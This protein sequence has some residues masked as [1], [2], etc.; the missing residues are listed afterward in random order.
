[1]ARPDLDVDAVVVGA[2]TAGANAAYQLAGRGLRVALVERRAADQGGAQWSNG[3]LDWQFD[4]AGIAPPAPPE[5]E[6]AHVRT[7]IVG[8][9]GSHG[10]TLAAPPTVGADMARLGQR[11]RAL[12][13]D[14]GV[15][16]LDRAEHRAVELSN[17]RPTAVEVDVP[18]DRGTHRVRLAAP[19]FVDA[20]GRRGVLRRQVPALAPWCPTVRGDELCTAADVH[21]DVVDPDGARRFLARHGAQPG[22]TVTAV[23]T[24]GGFSTVAV[25]VA[26]D[27]AHA[28]VL[29]G[30]LANGRYG[31]GPRML[32]DLRRREAWLGE[33]TSGG[34]GVI[35]LR[36]P[37]AR[38]TAPGI[39]LVGDAACQVFPAHGSGIGLGLIAGTMLAEAVA[40]ADD[41][42]DDQAL[43]RYQAGFQREFG[44]V[45][46]SSDAF[47]RLS[48]ELGGDGVAEL[49]RA[50]LMLEATAHAALDQRW[51]E[52]SPGELATMA[53]RLARHPRL[54]RR[55]LPRL[56][57][58]Q[59]LGALA[60]RYPGDP[61]LTAL[62]RW[63]HRVDRLLGS[64]PR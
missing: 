1:M 28:R 55:M 6:S 34:S 17:G 47:R 22:E 32:D 7:H 26:D 39:A 18:G 49:V 51:P 54:A 60:S 25:G 50:G 62:A 43:W 16:V 53:R 35:P 29:V 57:R 23:G 36:R 59:L 52:P 4:R 40:G 31:T 12:A 61:D 64:L 10:V 63:D 19:L 33:V 44:G 42:G 21:L 11:V 24:N 27:L 2:G 20:S 3:V 38:F 15:E 41:P 48:T 45:L 14:A 58:A 30:C 8:P 9:D 13:V 46:A 56:A 5:R 37:Y